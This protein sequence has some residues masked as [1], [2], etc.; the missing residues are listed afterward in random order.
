M[1]LAWQIAKMI[2]HV[3]SISSK[4]KK[5]IQTY[6]GNADKLQKN[7]NDKKIINV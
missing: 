2:K 3:F 1:W 7:K 4:T 5:F 6:N